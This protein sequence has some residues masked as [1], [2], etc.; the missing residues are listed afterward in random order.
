ML[1]T[2]QHLVC[3]ETKSLGVRAR[4]DKMTVPFYRLA[5]PSILALPGSSITKM[6]KEVVNAK[7]SIHSHSEKRSRRLRRRSGNLA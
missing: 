3:F 4:S 5:L 6:P 7:N 1:S 2:V